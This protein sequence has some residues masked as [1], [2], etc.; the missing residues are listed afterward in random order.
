MFPKPLTRSSSMLVWKSKEKQKNV[1]RRIIVNRYSENFSQQQQQVRVSDASRK[2][3]WFIWENR[4]R[5]KKCK[6]TF[7]TKASTFKIETFFVF[8]VPLLVWFFGHQE[9]IYLIG[10]SAKD[11]QLSSF[12]R[13][14]LRNIVSWS[15]F[16]KLVASWVSGRAMLVTHV[17]LRAL[18]L[19]NLG[20]RRYLSGR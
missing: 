7:S 20:P 5:R 12:R 10:S 14:K 3:F 8:L 16:K 6:N 13:Q 9:E 1:R 11:K 15:Y 18:K 17:P 2:H 4:E 19:G